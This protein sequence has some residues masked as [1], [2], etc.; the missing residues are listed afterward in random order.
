MCIQRFFIS[1]M[2]EAVLATAI[3]PFA[4]GPAGTVIITFVRPAA[5]LATAAAIA[6][7]G[8]IIIIII[9]IIMSATFGTYGLGND[10]GGYTNGDATSNGPVATSRKAAS[11]LERLKG[12]Q[13]GFFDCGRMRIFHQTGII[14]TGTT[15]CTDG[16]SCDAKCYDGSFKKCFHLNKP[17]CLYKV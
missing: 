16:E 3:V 7:I 8:A 11:D 9:I 12:Q 6:D 13:V 5:T 17:L 10:E 1:S 14:G 15:Y 4:A 2:P